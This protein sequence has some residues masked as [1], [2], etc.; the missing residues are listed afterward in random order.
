M[1]KTKIFLALL[2]IL[3][4]HPIFAQYMDVDSVDSEGNIIRMKV[5]QKTGSPHSIYGTKINLKKYGNLNNANMEKI[6]KEF[7]KEYRKMLKINPPD[8]KL[9][10][11]I[12]YDGFWH[13]SFQQTYKGVDVYLAE[14]KFS[15]HENG[16]VVI[17]GSDVYNNISINVNP[18][19]SP[20]GAL[21]IAKTK[22]RTLTQSDSINIRKDPEILIL[23]IEGEY[24]YT[25][26]LCYRLQLD[27]IG[28]SSIHN[29][30]YFINAQ[31]GEV[32][33][34]YTDIKN[35]E[36]TSISGNVEI[37][38]FEK[39]NA[40]IKTDGKWQ[41]GY[42]AIYDYNGNQIWNGYTDENGYYQSNNNLLP[43]MPY[44]IRTDNPP[45]YDQGIVGEYA[46][47]YPYLPVVTKGPIYTGIYNWKYD[48]EANPPNTYVW[49]ECNVYVHM[50]FARD[51]FKNENKLNVNDYL[52]NYDLTI[53]P[54]EPTY[55]WFTG[56]SNENCWSEGWR[57]GFG[58]E[59]GV[60]WGLLTE[61][62]YHEYAHCIVYYIYHE[63]FIG[64][65]GENPILEQV[66][67]DEGFADYFSGS[68]T[69]DPELGENSGD[70][71]VDIRYLSNT[72]I[73]SNNKS[74]YENGVVI[75][76][77]CWDLRELI[78]SE[79]GG[80]VE[81]DKK[82]IGALLIN[83]YTFEDFAKYLAGLLD[84]DGIPSNGNPYYN[85]IYQ[86]FTYNHEIE[87]ENLYPLRP[88]VAVTASND[89]A[90]EREASE[91]Q[92]PG[93][94][95]IT[96]DI[97]E[98]TLTVNFSIDGTATNDYTLSQTSPVIFGAGIS[99]KTIT[100]NIINDLLPE[101][102]E[103]VTLTLSSSD[104]YVIDSQNSSAAVT[105][106][107]NDVVVNITASDPNASEE[108]PD[109]GAFT[110]TR[111]N[112]GCPLAVNYTVSGSASTSDY[113]PALSN[114]VTLGDN[115]TSKLIIISPVD[116]SNQE[117]NE[118]VTLTLSGGS[119]YRIGTYGSATVTIV[120]ND[121]ETITITASDNRASEVGP[122][123]TGTFI[124]TRRFTLSQ[125]SV[126]FSIGGSANSGDYNLSS[127]SPITF[128]KGNSTASITV[129]PV[130]DSDPEGKE[131]VTLTITSGDN[132]QIG[133]PNS[134]TVEIID[135]EVQSVQI[136]ANDNQLLE[137]GSGTGTFTLT[138]NFIGST[139]PVYFNI[140]GL[141]ENTIDYNIYPP[142]PVTFNAS[143]SSVLI[144]V[145]PINDSNP[146]AD[147]TVILSLAS[148][149]NYQIDSPSSAT[150]TIADNDGAPL[151][152]ITVLASDANAEEEGPNTGT[153]TF[154]RSNTTGELT[155]Y[156]S[157]SGTATNTTD[158]TLSQSDQVTFQAGSSSATITV[159]P[160][161]D[162]KQDGNETVT[163]A[164]VSHSNYYIG[165]PKNATVRITD[166]D[167][168]PWVNS[169]TFEDRRNDYLYVNGSE[170]EPDAAIW[171]W[172]ENNDPTKAND[173]YQILEVWRTIYWREGWDLTLLYWMR[174]LY[175]YED[176]IDPAQRD[177][178]RDQFDD[179]IRG[180]WAFHGGS[181]NN[182]L[183]DFVVR[184]LWSQNQPN[185]T[186]QYGEE[187]FNPAVDPR[188][189]LD[190]FTYDGRE[191]TLTNTYNSFELSRDWLYW[192][193]DNLT[194]SGNGNEELDSEY[195]KTFITSLYTLY[196][197]AINIEMKRRAK[198]MLDFL[199]LD[200]ILDVSANLHGGHIGRTYGESVLW[201]HPQIYHWIYWGIGPYPGSSTQ[202]QF[203]D[204]YVSS[205][206]MPALIEDIGVLDD[207]PDNYWHLNK[208]NNGAGYISG[209]TGKWTYVTKYYN[210]GGAQTEKGQWMLNVKSSNSDAGIRLWIN[211][212]SDL[213][214]EQGEIIECI[215][216]G[217][218]CHITLGGGAYQ[219]K[220]AL[221][222]PAVT[223]LHFAELDGFNVDE[224]GS[225]WRFFREDKVAVA[226]SIINS[227]YVHTSGSALEVAIVEDD[228]AYI[229]FK[230]A[231]IQNTQHVE[232][233]YYRK[234]I[235]SKGD[236]LEIL[237]EYPDFVFYVNGQPFNNQ[238]P[239]KRLETEFST[240]D[241]ISW[242]N[243]NRTMTINW[244]SSIY[245][246]DFTD[247]I[248]TDFLSLPT[249]NISSASDEHAS[250]EGPDTGTFT[251]TRSD[252]TGELTVY[253]TI[254]GTATNTTDYV[255]SNQNSVTFGNG[256][257]SIPI[258]VTPI[259]DIN[260]ENNE[261]VTLTLNEN[262]NY[263]I[264]SPT[265]ATVIITDN[266]IT[267]SININNISDNII[268]HLNPN[269]GD[270]D[271]LG[272]YELL[273]VGNNW[274][275]YTNRS[276]IKF[277]LANLGLTPRDKII[278]ASLKLYLSSLRNYDTRNVNL[279]KILVPWEEM[280]S[281]WSRPY[282][283]ADI[284]N[285]CAQ[286]DF[287]ASAEPTTYIPLLDELEWHA[288]SGDSMTAL[289][290]NWISNPANN[291]GVLIKMAYDGGSDPKIF[292]F[293][294]S[295]YSDPA[296]R[297]Y[298]E[299][300][301]LKDVL[302]PE[303]RADIFTYP[304]YGKAPLTVQFDASNSYS[305]NGIATYSWDFDA[306]NGI[307]TEA[308]GIKVNHT[309]NNGGEFLVTLTTTDNTGIIKTD[310]LTVRCI[311]GN[312]VAGQ[313]SQNTTWQGTI[314]FFNNVE[315]VG[316]A[317]LTILP[318][319][320]VNLNG[321]YLKATSGA[322]QWD[323][324]V[325]FQPHF[326]RV[327][328]AS[329][330]GFY[331]TIQSAI[332]NASYP[333]KVYLG[334]ETYSENLVLKIGVGIYGVDKN[335]TIIDGTVELNGGGVVGYL[336]VRDLTINKETT[337]GYAWWPC[338]IDI[339]AKKPMSFY[340]GTCYIDGAEITCGE[341]YAIHI[342][343][344]DADIVDLTVHNGGDVFAMMVENE[345][346]LNMQYSEI[347][348]CWEAFYL[349]VNSYAYVE[350]S[351][352]CQNVWDASSWSAAADFINNTLSGNPA[353][354]LRGDNIYCGNYTI[355]SMGKTS[356]P[357]SSIL[358]TEDNTTIELISGS[359]DPGMT[360]FKEAMRIYREIQKAQKKDAKSEKEIKPEKYYTDYMK[361]IE[362]LKKVVE[363]HP[364]QI[365]AKLALPHV[366]TLYWILNEKQNGLSYLDG[367][368]N[369][370]EL[371][372]LKPYLLKTQITYALQNNDVDS[373]LTISDQFLT[374]YPQHEMAAVVLYGKGI[375][376]KH[377]LKNITQANAIF[378]Q[379]I[380]QYPEHRIATSAR[381]E[382][383]QTLK[384]QP[385]EGSEVTV[386][387]T[388]FTVQN[389]PNPF[390]PE[391]IIQYSLPKAGRVVL[392]IY[393]ILGREVRTL[394]D[395]EKP[396]GSHTI[397]WDGKDQSGRI[398]ASGLYIYQIRFRDQVLTR[399][400]LLM[401]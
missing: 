204:A 63:N 132:Y 75:G 143:D 6:G 155:V 400:M 107:D 173:I 253:F 286:N 228:D 16:N 240:G 334:P 181:L 364:D 317:I 325:V 308:T 272:N 3:S 401:R 216:A 341:N 220:Y 269:N 261:T 202:G 131:T 187:P 244:K 109:T 156:F 62:I 120:D 197:F 29:R 265:N 219:H 224:Q 211:N 258:T 130:D 298:L 221:F 231:V 128:A 246:Y 95:I 277:N 60:E 36:P 111:N 48:K 271:N 376:Y 280:T 345:T 332:D 267:F 113:T 243:T 307:S 68:I 159:T 264:G 35:S 50:N 15:V 337:V 195:T 284:W 339:I 192:T 377:L 57:I 236:I 358:K 56:N 190:E 200:S 54:P 251:V 369:K 158:Y 313:I 321:Y 301:Y 214:N 46:Y 112:T 387:I 349:I 168:I 81:F 18:N 76:G 167:W 293:L 106:L 117:T 367:L 161:D 279:H 147:E 302:F 395:E 198:M 133:S 78:K 399:K 10:K 249:V 300:V 250:E 285:G 180:N 166:N 385:K 20:E 384:N 163:L 247:W 116:D 227:G 331:S 254:G 330:V 12:F 260:P 375:I 374:D 335:S 353:N 31:N 282:T 87:V 273:L 295:E 386:E 323:N 210:L 165:S 162:D 232:T 270:E 217:E 392:T 351:Y 366:A 174:I 140:E 23:P 72:G 294:S 136:V 297:P 129:T 66:S 157:T 255:I 362:K 172:L 215:D 340:G 223:Y 338:F 235:T 104:D 139:L 8:F 396:T 145:T 89:N 329:P 179:F 326:V 360:D 381:Y 344:T 316:G 34:E 73:Y 141:A 347:T 222:A 343:N 283:G 201:G 361:A 69:H 350:N 311:G 184:Y 354:V 102:T 164:I 55:A 322:I 135:N 194:T 199:L 26:I 324:S 203:Y 71:R 142:S 355:C 365:S 278:T 105:I 49:Q 306:S 379:V 126:N 304:T 191:Y 33:K 148:G 320:V 118:T 94:F 208:E 67:M 303:S 319:T 40:Q 27:D 275:S 122:N 394:I 380:S 82:V 290:Q 2:T 144:T 188:A 51:Y 333:Q 93:T 256:V 37:Q 276:L 58:Q 288:W 287:F 292:R 248:C 328:T 383:G 47:V 146:E 371:N 24:E 98:G 233:Q 13:V 70:S 45:Q 196:D 318:G 53:G 378:N 237:G 389:Y 209:S 153:F 99:S 41:N 25:Y 19:I 11:S 397:L 114:S 32:I 74:I 245:D 96:R 299:I 183:F 352:F 309:F 43:N 28:T 97:T 225:G 186:V 305:P 363:N 79:L 175:Q 44:Q 1:W 4:L 252:A 134:A 160:I 348:D 193:F 314:V 230:N 90:G 30:V 390:N 127:N 226:I 398:S 61:F 176:R 108:G 315:I 182:R 149:E 229:D 42:I 289:V 372:M 125:L 206:R 121:I 64:S 291:H 91:E 100:V 9:K 5:N 22:F 115:E 59:Y 241:N 92:N 207:E 83:P 137:G 342:Y 359:N 281:C 266:D 169:G 185:V 151:P 80:A 327:G 85:E 382:L 336:E 123:N 268:H 21:E 110:I 124:F 296:Y 170:L 346:V 242:D 259:N 373:A 154:I 189:Q 84:D 171:A 17:L 391:T 101:C 312:Y 39:N 177:L 86:A 274:A 138:R 262:I 14:V 234:F 212:K 388:E 218:F 213:F 103:N 65:G 119:G 263:Q 38:Y 257:Q 239:F 238:Y 310:T 370:A 368:K 152:T 356:T 178:V 52:S 88:T 77:A 357:L 7:L 393:D 205:Y 150:I